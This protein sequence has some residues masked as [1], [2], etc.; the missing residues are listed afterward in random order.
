MGLLF[1]GRTTSPY[2]QA[3]Q[4]TSPRTNRVAPP[5]RLEQEA[6]SVQENYRAAAPP[7]PL[8][9]RGHA[10]CRRFTEETEAPTS[11]AT[12]WIS[13]PANNACPANIRRACSSDA[14]PFGLISY[15]THV[16]QL[17]HWLY[18]NQ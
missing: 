9:I 4:R 5:H 18:R 10:R 3:L 12:S 15:H 8:F 11:S 17:V 6:A 2:N 16:P 14:L 13:W 7:C 1:Y